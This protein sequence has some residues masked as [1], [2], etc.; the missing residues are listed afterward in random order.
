M[1]RC[2]T[3]ASGLH[4]SKWRCGGALQQVTACLTQAL[5]ESRV[6]LV[7]LRCAVDE[8]LAGVQH[9]SEDVSACPFSCTVANSL[10]SGSFAGW[11]R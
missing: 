5:L 1:S 7:W 11:G 2:C 3:G 4:G 9:S 8:M 10:Q 6:D